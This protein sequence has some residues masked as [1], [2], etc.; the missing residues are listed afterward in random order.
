MRPPRNAP[1]AP[2][3]STS[4][5]SRLLPTPSPSPRSPSSWRTRYL[6]FRRIDPRP[7]PPSEFLRPLAMARRPAVLLPALAYT[8]VFAYAGVFITVLVP[9][10]FQLKFGLDAAQVGLQFISLVVGAVLGEQL[11]G[12]GSD[13][14]VLWRA[15]RAAAARGAGG[16]AD[17]EAA[18]EPE[19]RLA[20]SYPGFVL[21]TVGLV[22]WGVQLQNAAPGRW[23]VTPD[24]GGGVAYFGL[25]LVTTPLYAYCLES[26]RADPRFRSRAARADAVLVPLPVRRCSASRSRSTRRTARSPSATPSLRACS[27]RCQEP[28]FSW[29]SRARYGGS[30]GGAVANRWSAF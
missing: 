29:S 7:I 4:G 26:Y 17:V 2:A 16:A 21:A 8:I 19:M 28:A 9:Q 5:S 20:A 3:T 18:R 24:V 14:L 25:Q 13:R 10:F 12:W 27:R 15:R 22:V 30:G 23:N 6:G 1:P 11:A